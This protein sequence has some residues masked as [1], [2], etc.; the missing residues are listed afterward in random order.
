MRK[1]VLFTLALVLLA[2]ISYSQDIII[3]TN[4]NEVEAKVLEIT[5]E[6][7]KYKNYDHQDGP[8][9]NIRISDVFMIKYEN[10]EKEK[11][12]TLEEKKSDEST[13]SSEYSTTTRSTAKREPKD[14]YDGN[15]FML[16]SGYGNSYGGVGV[17]AQWRTG[18][19]QGFGFHV[20]GGYFPEAPV[21]VS[22][23]VKFFPYKF[24]YV[25]G[26]FGLTGHEE[27]YHY[28]SFSGEDKE[29]QLLYGPSLLTGVDMA[30]GDDTG[31]GFNAGVGA[32][33]NINAEI[34]NDITVA[35]DVGFVLRF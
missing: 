1:H 9:R 29:E 11:F 19:K 8:I 2:A 13:E 30:W 16:A 20:G 31:Y 15:Y 14:T 26:Q 22:A 25:N 18:G 7:I 3:K 12:N 10:G 6:K 23:G 17:R 28:S 5:T 24:I 27:R 4:G 21:L 33:Y 35:L 32:T 34:M